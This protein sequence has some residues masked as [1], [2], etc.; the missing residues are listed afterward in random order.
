MSFKTGASRLAQVARWLCRQAS[1]V[2]KLSGRMLAGLVGAFVFGAF[3]DDYGTGERWRALV[4]A[5]GAAGLLLA[6][7][8]TTAWVMA[9]FGEE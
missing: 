7:S 5:V 3:F 2:I 9:G 8:E 6:A 1:L 4:L